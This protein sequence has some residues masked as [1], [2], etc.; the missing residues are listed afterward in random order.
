MTRYIHAVALS[1]AAITLLTK[2]AS[3]D[4]SNIGRVN[5]C[6]SENKGTVAQCLRLY[7]GTLASDEV[8]RSN[9]IAACIRGRG[10]NDGESVTSDQ[11]IGCGLPKQGLD[12]RD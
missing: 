1:V 7:A 9:E 2:P 10:Y 6:L 3:A 5:D 12:F 8:E 4:W 11:W